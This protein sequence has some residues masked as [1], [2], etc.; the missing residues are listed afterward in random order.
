MRILYLT[1][2]ENPLYNTH[3]NQVDNVLAAVFFA[4]D[5]RWAKASRRLIRQF[6]GG[7]IQPFF[8][9]WFSR[10]H[11]FDIILISGTIYSY[12]IADAL[13]RRGLRDKLVHWFWNPI[14]AGDRIRLLRSQGV[15][16]FTFDPQDAAL[17]ELR[18]ETT[19]Y[20]S[21][22]VPDE[23]NQSP[24]AQSTDVFFVG[25]D[26]GRLRQLI[27][28]HAQF[29]GSGLKAIFHITDT[30]HADRSLSYPFDRPIPY[31]E[32]IGR[33]R[34]SRCLLDVVQGGQ[35]GLT[36]RPMEAIFHGRKLITNDSAIS[37]Q[38]F[39]RPENVF[40]LG[41]DNPANLASFVR[42]PYRAVEPSIIK[43]YDFK[44]W[45]TRIAAEVLTRGD[46]GP[47]GGRRLC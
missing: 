46:P 38:D 36:Q 3:R 22:L 44:N 35:R 10:A 26:K 20:F 4:S 7:L 19:Y 39:Y 11:E 8:A 1:G 14:T 16:I 40:I 47:V 12:S 27:E 28:L 24:S 2:H 43:R 15:P 31:S 42:G 18:L 17:H 41:K 23:P 9:D 34:T 29:A 13:I 45:I 30:G 5:A 25:G 37:G 21:T 33:I 6:P 32:V